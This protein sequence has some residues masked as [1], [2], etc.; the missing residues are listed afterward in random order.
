MLSSCSL[1]AAASSTSRKGLTLRVKRHHHHHQGM[2]TPPLSLLPKPSL[3][4][5]QRPFS[6]CGLINV[7]E[8]SDSEGESPSDHLH[9]SRPSFS[10][11]ASLGEHHDMELSVRLW[12]V[13]AIELSG[14]VCK[15]IRQGRGRAWSPTR[16]PL[17][18][19]FAF[20]GCHDSLPCLCQ[21]S[22]RR[23]KS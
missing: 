11:R 2:S 13:G 15:L 3:K 20:F 8:G 14:P 7:A 22:E 18:G 6:S 23:R 9:I 16:L 12:G 4:D 21:H 1:A 5:R 10:Q 19:E 17:A